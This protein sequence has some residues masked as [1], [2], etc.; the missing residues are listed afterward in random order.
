MRHT[1]KTMTIAVF[2]LAG[3]VFVCVGEANPAPSTH[4]IELK[5]LRFRPPTLTV[6][7]GDTVVWINHDIVPHTA[8]ELDGEWDSEGLEQDA[9]WRHVV[10][11]G[12]VHYYC[13][14]HPTMRGTIIVKGD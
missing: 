2:A 14:Y 1:A 5:Q 12:A 8:T 10:T 13:K 6:A 9:S 3:F 7:R 11:T 4:V